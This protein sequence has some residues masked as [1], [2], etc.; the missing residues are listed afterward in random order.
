MTAD[1]FIPE[2]WSALLVEILQ[3]KMDI[4]SLGN[5]EYEGEIQN[6]GDI[7]NIQKF[8]GVTIRDYPAT[9]DITIDPITS[10]TQ[11]LVI[12][13]KKYFAMEVEDIDQIQANINLDAPI[14]QDAAEK[15]QIQ[16]NDDFLLDGLTGRLTANLIDA[17]AGPFDLDDMSAVRRLFDINNVPKTDRWGVIHPDAHRDLLGNANFIQADQ[18]GSLD[19]TRP[20]LTGEVGQIF[21][22]RLI[23]SN[24][25]A[26]TGATP[27]QT[28]NM[29]FH[30]SAIAFALQK[31]LTIEVNRAEKRFDDHLRGF[32]LYGTKLVQ[33]SALIEVTLD[34]D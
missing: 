32:V 20:L 22:I 33:P 15:I 6:E 14:I 3:E 1:N 11:Q 17:G 30:R 29:F 4:T 8:G 28:R 7:V 5:R 27:D 9:A 13:K 34:V 25:I 21:G 26:L 19:P 16:M 24:S 2:V 12:N 18:Y 31:S 10:T 23:T